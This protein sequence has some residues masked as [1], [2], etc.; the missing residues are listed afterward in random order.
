MD[1]SIPPLKIFPLN[2]SLEILLP[3]VCYK[4]LFS[5]TCSFF[6]TANFFSCSFPMHATSFFLFIDSL[7]ASY[8]KISFLGIIIHIGQR[9]VHILCI[10]IFRILQSKYTR[11]WHFRHIIFPYIKSLG[12]CRG[13]IYCSSSQ[14]LE[15]FSCGI[16]VFFLVEK[17]LG[18][19]Y[20]FTFFFS[21]LA[22]MKH[23]S[24]VI[25]YDQQIHIYDCILTKSINIYKKLRALQYRKR[26]PNVNVKEN[27][28]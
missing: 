10:N 14:F 13:G 3:I 28:K 25:Y 22:K 8:R 23:T 7:T 9:N 1:K 15:R 16:P 19:W 5:I 6:F 18:F 11:F 20:F 27:I 24:D 26:L 17:T 2:I 12:V 4:L 21:L